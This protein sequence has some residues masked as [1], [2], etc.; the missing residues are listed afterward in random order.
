MGALVIFTDKKT[1]YKIIF[2]PPT[3]P[4]FKQMKQ[5]FGAQA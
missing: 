4:V 1:I 3:Y 5:F 2:P